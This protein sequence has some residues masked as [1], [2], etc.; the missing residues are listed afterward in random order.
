[1]F[2]IGNRYVK[3]EDSNANTL[4]TAQSQFVS[5]FTPFLDSPQL[6]RPDA[7]TIT[8]SASILRITSVARCVYA[9][10]S[11]VWASKASKAST[12]LVLNTDTSCVTLEPASLPERIVHTDV[13]FGAG[14][15]AETIAAADLVCSRFCG[16]C[17]GQF[18]ECFGCETGLFLSVDSS[19]THCRY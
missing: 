19:M 12:Q 15:S 7:D 2:A 9:D 18:G 6:R 17:C 11:A 3:Y 16:G 14:V 13:S 4:M 10:L 5:I 1:L 8:I